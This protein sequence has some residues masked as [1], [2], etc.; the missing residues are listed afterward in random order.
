M[1]FFK[2]LF[3]RRSGEEMNIYYVTFHYHGEPDHKY[4]T[5]LTPK[6]NRKRVRKAKSMH[7][8]EAIREEE[9]V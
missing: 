1:S 7:V 5:R 6:P 8:R 9:P 3:G 2:K 4:T